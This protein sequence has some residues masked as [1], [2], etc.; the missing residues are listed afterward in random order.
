MASK[1]KKIDAIWLPVS[2]MDRAVAFYRDTLGL[3]V[4]EH[5]GDWSEVTAGDQRIG[6]N[7]SESPSGDGGAVIA[8]GVEGDIES[9]VEALRSAGVEFAGGLSEHPWGKIAPFKD[10][11]GNDLQLYQPPS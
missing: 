3:E 4:L 8:F 7:S 10:S 5:D 11:E 9:A 6:L 2:D 1:L